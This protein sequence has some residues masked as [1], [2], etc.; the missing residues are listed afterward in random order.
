MKIC[1][2]A[3][4]FLTVAAIL[5]VT[6]YIVSVQKFEGFV[7]SVPIHDPKWSTKV[8][9]DPHYRFLP[10]HFWDLANSLDKKIRPEYW[11]LIVTANTTPA[12][13]LGTEPIFKTK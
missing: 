5:Y 13:N 2:H 11:T 12:S 8:E 7:G 4:I 1:I 6:A 10:N 3:L 9:F